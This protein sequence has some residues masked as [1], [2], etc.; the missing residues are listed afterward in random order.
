MIFALLAGARASR[1]EAAAKLG[2]KMVKE[3]SPW[4]SDTLN[5]T[6]I[7]GSLYFAAVDGVHGYELWKSDGTTEGTAILKDINPH[8][9]GYPIGYDPY[10]VLFK[11]SLYFAANDGDNG[12]ELWKSDGTEAGT[13]MFKDINKVKPGAS[14]YPYDLT[15]VNDTLFFA[16]DDG[17]HGAEFWKSDGTESGTVLVKDVVS[18]SGTSYLGSFTPLGGSL[19]FLTIDSLWKSDG[20]EAGTV[21]VTDITHNLFPPGL[22]VFN[23]ALYFSGYDVAHNTELWKSDGI[24]ETLG[25]TTSMVKD[26][27]PNPSTGSYPWFPIVFGGDLYFTA[28]DGTHGRE[29][30]ESDGT[31]TGTV[32]VKDINLS[33]DGSPEHLSALGG[34]LYFA[35]NDGYHGVELWKSDGTETGT[36]MVKDI[37]PAGDGYGYPLGFDMHPVFFDGK[38]YF[39][40]SDGL[41]SHGVEL[42]QSD[43]TTAGTVMVEDINPSGDSVPKNFIVF[44]GSVY[45]AATDGTHGAGLWKTG[46]FSPPETQ[47]DSGPSGT[48]T[49]SSASFT[50]SADEAS[51][52]QCA[53]DGAALSACTSPKTFSGL[54]NGS[55]TFQ[56][57]ATDLVGNVD[58]SP[59]TSTFTVNVSS[60][61]PPKK[62]VTAPQTTITKHPKAVVT[63]SATK[64]KAGFAFKSS[65][66]G[67]HFS[68]KLDKSKWASC[69]SPKSY[70]VG[71]GK[72]TF[73]V[74]AT[75]SAGKTD[76]TPAKWTWTVKRKLK[77]K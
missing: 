32:M 61:A 37:N 13:V 51:T 66:S 44:K 52:F 36:V 12:V 15:V 26:I 3:I 76:P 56:V 46:D 68:C 47:I 19:Y 33:G 25:G 18:G 1:S 69:R 45:F 28:D 43:G 17:I 6:I 11:G 4:G 49:T 75:S 30:W 21:P 34:S 42:W 74:R 55:H 16:A 40:A 22:A 64:A 24:P 50:F 62:T 14:S 10:P 27:N 57:Q 70:S 67:S 38:L 60:P 63:T 59:A 5:S 58:P 53:L 77:R 39:A 9:D 7:N 72:H 48:I 20:T 54:A 8:G 71:L 29:L 2:A 23:G 65:K 31:E 35:A 41:L 73:Q